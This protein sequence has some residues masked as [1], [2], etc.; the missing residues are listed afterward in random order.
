MNEI[1]TGFLALGGVSALFSILVNV[2][3]V[4]N[5]VKDGQSKKFMLVLNLLGFVI[6]ALTKTFIPQVDWAQ[7]DGAAGIVAQMGFG[8]LSLVT[9]FGGGEIT[10]KAL[11]G[12]P[13]IGKS[14]TLESK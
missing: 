7:V 12:V 11:R 5:I 13:I 1:L 2:G 4:A 10:Y 3:K 9:M 14:F 6:F 8:A